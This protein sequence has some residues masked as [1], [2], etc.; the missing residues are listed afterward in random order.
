[1][2]YDAKE[3]HPIEILEDRDLSASIYRGVGRAGTFYTIE[4]NRAGHHGG[5][6][7]TSTF[8]RY[9]H[10]RSLANLAHRSHQR[11]AALKAVDT[12]DHHL[13]KSPAI[14]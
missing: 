8:F 6:F 12:G 4:F 5:K 13:F 1:M 3:F 2:G 11:I 14:H 9:E 10:L 7:A